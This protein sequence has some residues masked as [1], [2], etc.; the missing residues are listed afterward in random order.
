MYVDKGN[1]A[2]NIIGI[3]ARLCF[4]AGLHQQ[5]SWRTYTPFQMHMRQ[6]IFWTVY[7]LDRRI[8]LSCGRPFSIRE[9]DIDIEQPAYLY[10][11]V[12]TFALILV[13]SKRATGSPS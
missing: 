1:A 13:L 7:F 9:G 2:Y 10:D 12:K 8:S 3:A 6:R 11:K 5:S 4:Q